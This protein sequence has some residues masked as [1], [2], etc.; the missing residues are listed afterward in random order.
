MI[1]DGETLPRETTNQPPVVSLAV[2]YA[3]MR[4]YWLRDVR[5]TAVA[6]KKYDEACRAELKALQDMGAAR[7]E[8]LDAIPSGADE[9]E[10]KICA[11]EDAAHS[12]AVGRQ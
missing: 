4:D 11:E 10:A 8:F 9:L 3:A 1:D 7:N 5:A 12:A 6:K 2:R